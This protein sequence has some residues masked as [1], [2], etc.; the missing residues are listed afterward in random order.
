M[1]EKIAI[2]EIQRP[3]V[4]RQSRHLYDLIEMADH[5]ILDKVLVDKRLYDII[6]EHRRNWIRL[7]NIKY[8]DLQSNTIAF[9][10]T[11]DLINQ[12]RNDYNKMR[13]GM[14]YGNSQPFEEV[15][16]KLKKINAQ[17]NIMQ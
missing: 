11:E 15:I 17:I 3:D 5:S 13:E 14:I 7:K 16:A 1:H 10:P 4:E 9:V 6:I 12:F 8:E 2:K